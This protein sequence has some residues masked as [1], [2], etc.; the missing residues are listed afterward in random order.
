MQFLKLA[1]VSILT[2]GLLAQGSFANAAPANPTAEARLI[3]LA[4]N[5]ASQRQI[6]AV[7]FIGLGALY[8][9]LGSSASSTSGSSSFGTLYIGTGVVFAGLGVYQYLTP[10]GIE[11][12]YAS[13]QKIDASNE[14]GAQNRE[15]LAATSLKR[16]SEES[17]NQ[18]MLGGGTLTLLGLASLG[19]APTVGAV[20][21]GY[22]IW[23]LLNPQE[24]ENEYQDYKLQVG[25]QDA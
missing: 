11:V 23:T 22:G 1:T 16:R 21:G 10:S 18:R 8:A 15:G 2:I 19:S 14:N 5:A 6:R 3:R 20:Y 4:D 12:D 24:V 13:V 25:Q 17:Y 9:I 7:T